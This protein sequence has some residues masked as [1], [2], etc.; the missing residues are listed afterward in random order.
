MRRTRDTLPFEFVGGS[1]AVDFVNTVSWRG[2]E[3]VRN[4][5]FLSFESVITWA[6]DGGVIAAREA[7]ELRRKA[8]AA[9]PA[10]RLEFRL[11]FRFRTALHALF[12]SLAAGRSAPESL[13]AVNRLLHETLR[14]IELAPGEGAL[15]WQTETEPA[16]IGTI[17]H[18]VALDA[19]RLLTSAS[20]LAR[21]KQQRR[22]FRFLLPK[23]CGRLE[24]H[25]TRP[26]TATGLV[27]PRHAKR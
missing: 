18:R 3:R 9:P 20:D 5:R 22:A 12:S 13:A 7:A 10:A 14:R 25:A 19:A 23:Y 24:P 27:F 21:R 26:V 4:E 17:R 6:L 16:G 8:L 1:P 11:L 2:E 15:A